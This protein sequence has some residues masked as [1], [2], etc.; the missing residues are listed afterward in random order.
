M[1]DIDSE[2]R[3]K[4]ATLSHKTAQKSSGCHGKKSSEPSGLA[5][6]ITRN[7]PCTAIPGSGFSG[8]KWSRW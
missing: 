3:L 8:E 7:N 1:N 6:F 4:G 5:S 2:W